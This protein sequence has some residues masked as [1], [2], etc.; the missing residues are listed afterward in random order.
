VDDL[1]KRF[2]AVEDRDLMLCRH[3]GVAWQKDMAHRVPY[4]SAY[5]D[6]CRAYEDREIANGI[7][8]GRIDLVNAHAG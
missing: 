7:N 1:I 3:R 5:F 2:D 4:D 6:K 8:A